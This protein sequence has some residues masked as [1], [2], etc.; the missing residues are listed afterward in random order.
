MG[1]CTPCKGDEHEKC[2]AHYQPEGG[3]KRKGHKI[4]NVQHEAECTCF[5]R[6]RTDAPI[7]PQRLPATRFPPHRS[8]LLGNKYPQD[9]WV[10]R[11]DPYQD[12][13]VNAP[14]F[15]PQGKR[16]PDRR[17]PRKQQPG[18]RRR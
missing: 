4:E 15:H 13:P 2:R 5:C 14:R 18:K 10:Q 12:A 9:V 1:M 7:E 16:R 17:D 6:V 11:G 8:G 3:I